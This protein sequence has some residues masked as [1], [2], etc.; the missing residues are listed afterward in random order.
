MKIFK[1]RIKSCSN[2]Q[3]WY[4]NYVG[5]YFYARLHYKADGNDEL[6]IVNIDANYDDM[7]WNMQSVD[8]QD[9][10]IICEMDIQIKEKK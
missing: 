5:K 7:T 6:Y 9:A 3:F 10:E 1:I 2:L 8:Y 4:K